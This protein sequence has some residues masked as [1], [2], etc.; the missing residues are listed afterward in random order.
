LTTK[1]FDRR[2][3]LA[4]LLL[5]VAPMFWAGNIVIARAY[6]AELPPFGTTYWRW[7]LAA[8]VFLPFVWPLLRNQWP[9]IRREVR[10]IAVL[11]VLGLS[12]FASLM[13]SGLQTTT[14]LNASFI[15]AMTPA[16]IPLIV[17]IGSREGISVLHGIGIIVSAIGAIAIISAGN[18]LRLLD[19]DFNRGDL[20]VIG[21]MLVW[22]VYSVI[23]R[24]RPKD[25]HPNVLLWTTMVLGSLATLPLALWEATTRPMPLT[26][27]ALMAISYIVL[28]PSIGAYFCFNRGIEIVG[29]NKGGLAMHLV[30]L[31][32]AVLAVLFLGEAFQIY[33]GVGILAIFLGI[34]LVTR[35]TNR[36]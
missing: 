20:M 6:R 1:T 12:G 31:F 23:V 26:I 35:A 36:S 27:N 9:V 18:P 34:G 16:I 14:A 30:P 15:M 19:G 32:G 13:Y 7:T 3:A 11:S 33:H 28:F 4:V 2:I 29:P 17:W 25:L 5:V 21:A 8:I 10:F 24:H 22:A